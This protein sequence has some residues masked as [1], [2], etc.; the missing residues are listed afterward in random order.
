MR[1]NVTRGDYGIWND[2]VYVIYKYKDGESKFLE[3]DIVNLYGTYTGLYSYK[4]VLGGTVTI[5]GINAK[6]IEFAQ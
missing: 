6:H 5:P 1:I 4:S 2:T 3:D